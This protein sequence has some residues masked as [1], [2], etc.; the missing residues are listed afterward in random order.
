MS[1][2]DEEAEAQTCESCGDETDTF[3]TLGMAGEESICENCADIITE[4]YSL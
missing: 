4:E 1:L 2:E 3:V